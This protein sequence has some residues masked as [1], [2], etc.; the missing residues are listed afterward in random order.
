MKTEHSPYVAEALAGLTR[1]Q[2]RYVIDGCVHGD[3]TMQTIRALQRKAL[4]YLKITSP[5]GRAGHLVLTP[6]GERVREIL[7]AR[8]PTPKAQEIE[9]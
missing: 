6:L 7:K 3:C 2:K 9:A 1:A 8:K 5:N 4:F